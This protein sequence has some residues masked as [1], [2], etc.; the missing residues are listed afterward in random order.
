M[1]ETRNE[2][3]IGKR[4]EGMEGEK[5]GKEAIQNILLCVPYLK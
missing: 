1:E 2:E 3:K 4:T 5:N